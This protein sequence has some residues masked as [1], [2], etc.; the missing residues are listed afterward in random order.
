FQINQNKHFSNNL[1]HK[2]N[3]IEWEHY[4]GINEAFHF[5]KKYWN[6]VSF[7]E[8]VDDKLIKELIDY[9]YEEVLK[10]FTKKLRAEYET[11]P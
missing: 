2:L 8:D 5:N 11:L 4:N 6:S 1:H 9:S 10:K 3:V 7:N